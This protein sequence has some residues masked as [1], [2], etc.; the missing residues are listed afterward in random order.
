VNTAPLTKV[1]KQASTQKGELVNRIREAVDKHESIYALGFQELRATHLQSIRVEFRDSRIFFGKNKIVQLALGKSSEDEYAD[2]LRR[3][4]EQMNGNV[5]IL[6]TDRPHEEVIRWFSNFEV[7][8]FAKQ[9]F[10][11]QA[12]LVLEAGPL[13]Q[14]PSPMLAELRKLGLNLHIERAELSL[15]SDF[16]VAESGVPLSPEQAKLLV[17]LG[18]K[19]VKFRASVLCRWSAGSFEEIST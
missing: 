1:K 9:G 17:H 16:V 11:P 5:G 6:A 7:E 2:N 15:L 12:D 4:S 10:V 8:D 19:L 18:M 14:F 3:V 13:P